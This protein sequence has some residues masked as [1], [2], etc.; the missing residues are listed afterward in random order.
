[1]VVKDR[2][3]EGQFNLFIDIACDLMWIIN[4]KQSEIRVF[5]KQ[6]IRKMFKSFLMGIILSIMNLDHM[7][8]YLFF[9]PAFSPKKKKK[10]IQTT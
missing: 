9:T 5:Y 2:F 4:N 10:K 6:V 7:V 1:M 3:Q 8:R